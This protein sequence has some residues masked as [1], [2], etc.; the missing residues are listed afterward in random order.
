VAAA[1]AGRTAITLDEL[2]LSYPELDAASA[3][4]ADLLRSLGSSPAI[5]SG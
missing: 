2:E 4:A 5:A 3:C 1:C